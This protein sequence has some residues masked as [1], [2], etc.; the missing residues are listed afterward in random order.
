MYLSTRGAEHPE[1]ICQSTLG[2]GWFPT[3]HVRVTLHFLNGLT[4]FLD[5]FVPEGSWGKGEGPE[6]ARRTPSCPYLGVGTCHNRVTFV[7]IGFPSSFVNL[8]RESYLIAK[9]QCSFFFFSLLIT[10]LLL[11]ANKH[12]LPWSF[13]FTFFFFTYSH[14]D[15]FLEMQ[16][17]SRIFNTCIFMPQ[18]EQFLLTSSPRCLA[19]ISLEQY[20]HVTLKFNEPPHTL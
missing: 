3:A 7:V 6:I 11:S 8:H 15:G 2:A 18:S 19:L 17:F 10:L 1:P 20:D 4:V 14:P 12:S 9:S 16:S 5:M 13:F